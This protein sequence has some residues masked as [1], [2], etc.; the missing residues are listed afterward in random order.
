MELLAPA[1]SLE[2]LKAALRYGADA[3][4]FSG[5]SYSL[6]A[7]SKNFN[8]ED[9]INAIDYVHSKGK[10]CYVTVNAFAHN[11]D[12][13]D[14]EKYIKNI[15]KADAFIIADPGIFQFIRDIGVKTPIHISTQANV[16]NYMAVKFWEKLGATRVVLA[17]ELSSKEVKE[18]CD[19]V[20]CEIEVFVHGSMCVAMS[21]RCLVSNYL[22]NKDAN[23]GECT[24]TCRW[25]YKVSASGHE[26]SPLDIHE[27]ESGTYLFNTKDLSLI[28]YLAELVDAGVKSIKIE[29]RMKSVMYVSVVTGVYRQALDKISTY[30]KNYSASDRHKELLESV[31]NRTFT[32]GFYG[33]EIGSEAHNYETS[34]YTKTSEFMG[35]FE[36]NSVISSRASFDK[37]DILHI[38]T[39]KMEEIEIIGDKIID[40]KTSEEVVRT[41]PNSKYM[42]NDLKD[43]PEGS[44]LRKYTEPC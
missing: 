17:R 38:L 10:K 27:D 14:M 39:P 20:K 34:G 33:G 7:K 28:D 13:G 24:Q 16:T 29:G 6:R 41:K 18:I 26:Q 2:K 25:N 11:D 36:K 12:F 37:G 3:I 44:L 32:S 1:G 42:L 31:S 40:I 35:V 5:D 8:E 23:K 43:I 15:Q 9:I 30:S 19:N 4:Y 21:G 22:N